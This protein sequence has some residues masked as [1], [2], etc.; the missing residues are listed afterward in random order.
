[1][2]LLSQEGGRLNIIGVGT[3]P[4]HPGG[5]ALSFFD[6]LDA[7]A[8]RGHRIRVLAPTVESALGV[9]PRRGEHSRRLELTRFPVPFVQLFNKSRDASDDYCAIEGRHVRE[10]LPR[11]IREERPDLIFIGREI[12]AASVP[13]IAAQSGLPCVLRIAGGTTLSL[14]KGGFSDE[15]TASLLD[16]FKR[17]ALMVSPAHHMAERINGLGIHGVRVIP[18]AIDIKRFSM[19]QRDRE[20]ARSLNIVEHDIVIAHV[21]NLQKIKRAMDL[22]LSAGQALQRDPSLLYLFIGDGVERAALEAKCAALGITERVRFTGWVAYGDVPAFYRLADMMVMP[23]E[24]ETLACAYLEAQACGCVLIASNIAAAR[25]VVIH[26]NTGLLFPTGDVDALTE[27]TL[28]I[29]A[30]P[31]RRARIRQA[32]RA[33][34]I[35]HPLDEAVESYIGL[36]RNAVQQHAARSRPVPSK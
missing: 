8:K 30:D 5:S 29:A 3:F 26:D 2:N 11:M 22:V 23:A 31:E 10:L 1:M 12:F 33:Q 4:P 9:E 19:G 13:E 6:I 7:C 15:L 21:S 34:V 14:L 20:L 16:G 18:N 32:A 27:L 24:D 35:T 25:E 36:F 17:V 28:A